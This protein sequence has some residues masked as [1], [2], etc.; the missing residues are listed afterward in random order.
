MIIE[1]ILAKYVTDKKQT[2]IAGSAACAFFSFPFLVCSFVVAGTANAGFNAILTT[3]LNIAFAGESYYIVKN[4]KTPI[5][6]RMS[7]IISLNAYSFVQVGFL[8]GSS[9]MMTLLNFMTAIFWGQLSH[10]EKVSVT[11]AQYSCGNRA[12]YAALCSFAVFIFVTQFLY[13]VAVILWRGEL[14]SEAGAYEEISVP[15]PVDSFDYKPGAPS[16]DL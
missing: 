13:S 15:N 16:A 6:V 2:L 12:A 7:Q 14:I 1:N 10:C 5:A 4:S 9:V 3:I 8:I 11:V